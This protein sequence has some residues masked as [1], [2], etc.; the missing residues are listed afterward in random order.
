MIKEDF[1]QYIWNYRL[2]N[3]EYLYYLEEKIE[4]IETGQLNIS[5]GPDFFNS[6]IKIGNTI[7]VG[8]VEIHVKS[9]DWFRHGHHKDPAYENVILHMV[10]ENDEQV[11]RNNGEEIPT[12]SLTFNPEIHK[13]YNALTINTEMKECYPYI[14]KMEKVVYQDWLGK[15]EFFRLERKTKEVE[16]MLKNNHF[17][18]DSVLYEMMAMAFGMKLNA[19]PFRLLS[20]SVPLNFVLKNRDKPGTLFSAFYGKAGFLNSKNPFFKDDKKLRIEYSAIKLLLP[21]SSVE[22]LAW[23]KMRAR[24]AGFPELRIAQFIGFVRNNFPFFER[25]K[26]IENVK[27]LRKIILDGIKMDLPEIKKLTSSSKQIITLPGKD[28][29]NSWIINSFVPILFFYG[30]FSNK[31][32]FIDRS[33]AFLEQLPPENNEILKKWNKFGL[34]S[35][36][37]FDS[38]ALIELKTQFCSKQKCMNCI[39][40]HQL[41]SDAAKK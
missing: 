28:T 31:H 18:W 15:L 33:I 23:K 32:F 35:E 14:V 1:L 19:E 21:G 11:F 39:I 4:V 5:S 2:F 36:N 25:L 9:S 26:S 38:Q 8:N 40:G 27:E 10:Y 3:S 34:I 17:H 29:L 22:A 6:K 37:A 16:V 12:A 20:Q 30:K 41:M 13:K 7:W 24:P